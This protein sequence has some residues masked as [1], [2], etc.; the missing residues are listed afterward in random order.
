MG[1][2]PSSGNSF[3]TF[4]CL[5]VGQLTTETSRTDAGEGNV[6]GANAMKLKCLLVIS[7]I[8]AVAL[9]LAANATAT[10]IEFVANLSGAKEVPPNL[11]PGTGSVTAI[12]DFA[13]HTLDLDVTFSGLTSPTIAAH[14]HAPTTFAFSGTAGVATQVPFF[15]GFPIGVTSGTYDHAFNTL[16][17]AFYNPDFITAHGGTAASAEAAFA[18]AVTDGRAYFNIHTDNFPRGEIRGFLFTPDSGPAIVCFG[19]GLIGLETFR[20]KLRRQIGVGL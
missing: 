14:I 2:G 16:D 15:D 10:P 11:S 12:F 4:S 5:T 9:T 7:P 6:K 3:V 19:L 18:S 17:P 20:R 8:I 1:L 13:A